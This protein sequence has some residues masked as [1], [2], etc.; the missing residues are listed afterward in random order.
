MRRFNKQIE[1]ALEEH[2]IEWADGQVCRG[3]YKTDHKQKTYS[4]ASK[5]DIMYALQDS[6]KLNCR[7]RHTKED[8]HVYHTFRRVSS[9]S[10]DPYDAIVEAAKKITEGEKR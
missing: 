7:Y 6:L 2:G 1:K 8:W 4:K 5:G 10:K 3:Y 9:F